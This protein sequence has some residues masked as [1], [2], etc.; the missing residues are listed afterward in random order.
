MT[1]FV[2]FCFTVVI[3]WLVTLKVDCWQLQSCHIFCSPAAVLIKMGL[4]QVVLSPLGIC[5]FY[6]VIKTM[7]G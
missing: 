6:S 2:T 5:L 1:S 4:D 3:G 7:E